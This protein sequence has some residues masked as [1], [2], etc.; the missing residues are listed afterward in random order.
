MKGLSRFTLLTA[1]GLAAFSPA[2]V[3]DPIGVFAL[4]DRVVFAPNAS[5]PET[6]QVWG[7]FALADRNDRNNYLKP[8]RGYL[9]YKLPARNAQAARAEWADLQRAAGTNDPVGFGTR[10]GAESRVRRA[11]ESPRDP[12]AYELG[13]GMVKMASASFGLRPTIASE[14][15]GVP[16]PSTPADGAQVRAGAVRLVVRNAADAGVTHYVFQLVGPGNKTETSP[17]QAAGK[18]ETSWTPTTKL[19]KGEYTWRVWGTKGSW[20]SQQAIATFSVDQ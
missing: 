10:Y 8:V 15:M 4:V 1:A 14:L 12:D 16:N 2:H 13:F 9:F 3:S 7:V 5:D 18:G 17:P 19:A 11:S 6:V 20:N